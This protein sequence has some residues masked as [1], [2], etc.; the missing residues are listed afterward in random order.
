MGLA[1]GESKKPFAPAP[2]SFAEGFSLN[3]APMLSLI[4]LAY[5]TPQATRAGPTRREAIARGLSSLIEACVRG[6]I[7]DA[8]LAGPPGEGLDAIADAAGCG[9]VEAAEPAV[10]LREALSRARQ[11]HVFLFRAGYAVERGFCD[12]VEDAFAY[13]CEERALILR[14][15]PDRLLTRLA[16]ALAEP[17][18]LIAQKQAIDAAGGA[19]LR[20]LARRLKGVELVVRARRTI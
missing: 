18:G 7:A 20:V 1:G 17:V 15:A 4:L 12:E 9:L 5:E 3:M 13:G 10:A 2:H 19:D 8:T 11:A 16:P 14:A 6:V